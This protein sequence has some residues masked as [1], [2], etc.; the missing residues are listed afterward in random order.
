MMR[1]IVGTSLRFRFIII[2]IA[3][4][5]VFFGIDRL[6]HMPIDVFPEFAPPMV[7]IQTPCL[8]LTPEEVED[9]VTIPLEEALA[10]VDGLDV[11]RSKSV[12]QLSAIK[13]I[14]E[15]GTDL[16]RARQVVQERVD[17]VTPSIPSWAS[18]PV[19]VPP[20]SATSRTMKIG[21]SS[22]EHSVIDLS[23]IAYWKIR[24]A[25]LGVEGVANVAIW[26]ERL[27]MLQV[28][29]DPK[30]LAER[31][32]TL[33]Q[34]MKT[35]ADAM[36]SG[37]LP[38]S[39]GAVV[40]TGGFI[41]TP[42]QRLHIRHVLPIVS[43]ETLA[44]LPIVNRDGETF[45][46]G[47]V[48]E[49]LV[50]HQPMIGD[51]I[52]NDD[53]GL[54]LIVEKFPWANTLDVT[55][56]VEEVLARLRPG[57]PG[58]EID[59][60]IFRPATFIEI[61]IDN[62]TTALMIGCVLVI[63]IL[64]AFL[65]EWRV[66]LISIVAIPLSLMAAGIV[67][68][69]QGATI[70]TMVL[71]GMVIALGAVVD[72]A[73][74]DIE[75]ITRRLRQ[76][77]ASGEVISLGRIILDA[78]V[79][80]RTA[81]VFASLIEVAALMPVFFME[82]L[83]GA[84]FKPLAG[85]YVLAILASMIVAMTVTPALA[86]ILLRNA[87]LKRRQSP[88]IKPLQAGYQAVLGGILRVPVTAY[89]TFGVVVLAGA[90][91]IPQ[92]GQSLLPSF[93]ERDFLMHWLTKPGTS[94][95]E[96]NRI[97]I[98][99]SHE[100]RAIPGVRNFGAHIGQALIMDEVVG[101]YF[102]ENWISIDPSVDY[103]ETVA[104]IQEVV[105]GYP[106][107]YRDVLT[108]LKERIREVLTGSH[109]AI[110]VRIFGNDLH[111]LREHAEAVEHALEGT[112]GLKELHVSLQTEQPQ[113]DVEVD[114][115]KAEQYGL[116]PGDVRRA[117]GV[118]VAGIEVGDIFRGGKAYDVQVWGTPEV[119]NSLTDIE[120]LLLDTPTGEQVR[121][122]DVARVEIRA[123]PNVVKREDMQ[124]RIDVGGNVEEGVALS[125]VAKEV[126]ERLNSV[127]FETG[128]FPV[129][130]GEYAERQKVEY[131]L[132][133][134][135]LV[136]MI[137]I[138]LLLHTS[139]KSWKLATMAFLTF[140]VALVGGIIAAYMA[141][142]IISLGSLVGFL[143]VLGIAARNGIMMISHFQNLELY[144]HET[145]GPDLILRG[146]RER[147]APILMTAL[148]TGLALTPLVVA[149]NIA[150][151]EIEYPMAV[152]IVGGLVTSTLLNLFVI[153]AL[154]L[155]FGRGTAYALER[156]DGEPITQVN[157]A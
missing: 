137:I 118:L 77:R 3:A 124:R 120:N 135:T 102:G 53:I 119:R 94:W 147:L 115:E 131:R 32:L 117:A 72:D 100:L 126:A 90:L 6:R 63:L 148:T 37:L 140:P 43:A 10:G 157:P 36:D 48:A 143:T 47:D 13:L 9:L 123:T 98:Q 26:G 29:V 30:R 89:A 75:N 76:R 41:D 61:S 132:Y 153:P 71:A 144:E 70:N 152:V 111:K 8:G 86:M 149:G 128:Y 130:L 91:I 50:E 44:E 20:L 67:L 134:F 60:E 25:L 11:M 113:I 39:D 31:G 82:G 81:I 51:G 56:G 55:H 65:W 95:P 110:T 73:I 138:M 42:N 87:P 121:L 62:L 150:G 103:D 69:W 151:H 104:K 4:A 68:Y 101:I 12:P 85:A 106:G 45:R 93:K 52:I 155:R 99:S 127:E 97:T 64:G 2:A 112:P 125:K 96:M 145:F 136:A 108:Y 142:G 122:K 105:D 154:Y 88:L 80:V 58:V 146:A 21:I 38:W 83:S 1:W 54:L 78:S 14:F 116:K 92:L 34:V 107:L 109:E 28:Q 16:L 74:I 133:T 66:A 33:E 40:G 23:M 114:L 84:F 5:M 7:E 49:V 79:E 129:L 19:M 17:M 46:L 27:E 24:Q 22:Q 57:L 156:T 18:P 35:T 59:H 141:G 139:F 15:P